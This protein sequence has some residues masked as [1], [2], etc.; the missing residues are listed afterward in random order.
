MATAPFRKCD[1]K[2]FGLSELCS[3][4][5]QIFQPSVWAKDARDEVKDTDMAIKSVK[6]NLRQWS[7][8]D[9]EHDVFRLKVKKL[10]TYDAFTN[11]SGVVNFY[12]ASPTSFQY[13]RNERLTTIDFI[14]QVGSL[15]GI[16]IGFSFLSA[17]EIIFW[18]TLKLL[19]GSHESIQVNKA[20][21]S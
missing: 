1:L 21:K 5:K 16:C 17:V 9:P 18:F 3:F 2:N 15:M 11:D 7:M 13:E 10:P 19:E 20:K 4:D 6:S 12:F 8:E 14:S